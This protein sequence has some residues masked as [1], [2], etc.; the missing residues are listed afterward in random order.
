MQTCFAGP[1]HPSLDPPLPPEIRFQPVA[2]TEVAAHLATLAGSD[3]AG[4]RTAEGR[5]RSH[6]PR[7][8]GRG[9]RPGTG[10]PSQRPASRSGFPSGAENL[11]EHAEEP[12][13]WAEFVHTVGA[14]T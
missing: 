8:P 4:H 10:P 12:K 6:S 2:A 14:R 1:L 3:P 9:G 5:K 13:T 11:P 7:P